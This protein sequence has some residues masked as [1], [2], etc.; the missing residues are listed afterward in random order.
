MRRASLKERRGWQNTLDGVKL[1]TT[2]ALQIGLSSSGRPITIPPGED[3]TEQAKKWAVLPT[4]LKRGT[5]V[6]TPPVEWTRLD[7]KSEI[8]SASQRKESGHGGARK[9]RSNR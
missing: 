3:V 5:V 7:M 2:F 9:N 1:V 6:A 8:E 4:L